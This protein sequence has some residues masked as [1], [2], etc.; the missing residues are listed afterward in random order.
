MN[1]QLHCP[2]HCI[3]PA[4]LS[5]LPQI[6]IDEKFFHH[7]FSYPDFTEESNELQTFIDEDLLETS[8]KKALERSG[9]EERE[10]GREGRIESCFLGSA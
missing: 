6:I 8:H 7:S 2:S 10:A 3:R 9:E 4:G 5:S 1:Q